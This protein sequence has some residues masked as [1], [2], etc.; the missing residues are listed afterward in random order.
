[1]SPGSFGFAWVNSAT[2]R[3]CLVLSVSRWLTTAPLR[4]FGLIRVCDGSLMRTHVSQPTCLAVVG[5]IR[6]RVVFSRARLGAA[7]LIG[8]SVV[9]LERT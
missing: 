8:F 9:S 6:V 3:D 1:M 4:V 2:P 5:I 7:G